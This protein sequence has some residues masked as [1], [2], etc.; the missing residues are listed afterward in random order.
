MCPCCLQETHVALAGWSAVACRGCGAELY[1]NRTI[2]RVCDMFIHINTDPADKWW[3]YA[4]LH[5]MIQNRC[6]TKSEVLDLGEQYG[7]NRAVI[8]GRLEDVRKM[9]CA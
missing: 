9:Q 3:G 7:F 8:D 1:K 4:Q 5:K 6:I 2:P